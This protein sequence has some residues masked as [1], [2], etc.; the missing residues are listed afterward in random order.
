[1]TVYTMSNKEIAIWLPFSDSVV[2]KASVARGH[3]HSDLRYGVYL[4]ENTYFDKLWKLKS[5][6]HKVWF[7]YFWE[8]HTK[9]PG[10]QRWIYVL[11]RKQF[12][13]ISQK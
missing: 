3:F 5:L 2:L 7:V 11:S 9:W 8:M 13:C 1:M 10:K 4:S 12:V 6:Y